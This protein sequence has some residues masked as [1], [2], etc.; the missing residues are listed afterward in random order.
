MQFN[1]PTSRTELINTLKEIFYYYRIRREAFQDVTLEDVKLERMSFTVL[2]ESELLEKA[3]KLISAKIF[4]EKSEY[5]DGITAQK[6]ANEQRV[7]DLEIE[8]ENAKNKVI[9]YY[10]NTQKA[11]EEKVFQNG[12]TNSTIMIDK[13]AELE[14]E[15][16]AK[17]AEIEEEYTS[18]QGSLNAEN[19]MLTYRVQKADEKFNEILDKEL[20]AKLEELKD[21]QSKIQREVFKYNNNMD[22]KEKRSVNANKSANAHLKIA[23]LEIN[24]QHF[25][26]DEL[27]EMGYYQDVL[28]CVNGYYNSLDPIEAYDSFKDEKALKIYLDHYY[29]NTLYLMRTRA[30][31]ATEGL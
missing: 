22:E 19:A 17:L 18:K 26:K 9:E 13:F 3:E 23:Y 1:I 4:R 27:V 16:N 5:V 24:G 21:E 12:F 10:A 31:D 8:K 7:S 28:E 11:L 20:V 6:R 14:S 2:S 15:K 25:S 30:M 29:E